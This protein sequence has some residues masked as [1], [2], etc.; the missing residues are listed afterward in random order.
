MIVPLSRESPKSII[1]Y[2]IYTNI[3]GMIIFIEHERKQITKIKENVHG[4]SHLDILQI[5]QQ[6]KHLNNTRY[7]LNDILLYNNVMEDDVLSEFLN[8]DDFYSM[9]K[10]YLSSVSLCDDI[11]IHNTLPIFQSFNAMYF[12]FQEKKRLIPLHKLP[13]TKKVS[14]FLGEQGKTKKRYSSF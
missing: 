6:K 2:Y 11:I 12:F 8:S 13:S 3:K 10:L 1:V 4:F 7:E 5:I 14:F 9:T